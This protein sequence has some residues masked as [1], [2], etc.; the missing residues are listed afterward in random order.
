[1][2]SVTLVAF[3]GSW[4]RNSL[5][6]SF[7][8]SFELRLVRDE[9]LDEVVVVWELVGLTVMA[10]TPA[11]AAAMRGTQHD[12]AVRRL[13][14]KRAERRIQAHN[15]SAELFDLT[16]EFA[17]ALLGRTAKIAASRARRMAALR[18]SPRERPRT[19]RSGG[20]SQEMEVT[21]R[22]S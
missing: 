6:R 3:I 10:E 12:A 4:F 2:K 5:T 11:L 1:M 15:R 18:S 21:G 8:K 20:A 7:R 13:Q 16:A 17:A 14:I 19:D 22:R 9:V